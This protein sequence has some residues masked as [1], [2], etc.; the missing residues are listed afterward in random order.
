MNYLYCVCNFFVKSKTVLSTCSLYQIW[1]IQKSRKNR[2]FTILEPR[3]ISSSPC[4]D[5]SC[6]DTVE[7]IAGAKFFN[8]DNAFL[9]VE[10]WAPWGRGVRKGRDFWTNASSGSAHFLP[11]TYDMLQVDKKPGPKGSI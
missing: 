1:K 8:P 9:R 6:F 4:F 5:V 10:F 2:V 7:I 3:H 11:L